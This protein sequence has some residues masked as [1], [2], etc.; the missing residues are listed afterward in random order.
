MFDGDMVNTNAILS[1]EANAEARE[2]LNSPASVVGPNGALRVGLST[3]LAR[4][5]LYNLTR[6]G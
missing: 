6:V 3:D 5:T 1:M 4:M 2:Y